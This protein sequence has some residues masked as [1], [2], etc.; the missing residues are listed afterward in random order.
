M[1]L[2][3]YYKELPPIRLLRDPTL[4]LSRNPFVQ[5]REASRHH[6][7]SDV[8]VKEVIAM[9]LITFSPKLNQ[10]LSGWK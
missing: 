3:L 10:T 5:L 2:I 1:P 8:L 9:P 6:L 7:L 4:K